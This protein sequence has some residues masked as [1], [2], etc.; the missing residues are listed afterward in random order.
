MLPLEGDLYKQSSSFF[1]FFLKKVEIQA[2]STHS[3]APVFPLAQPLEPPCTRERSE[4]VLQV[5]WAVE[6][7]ARGI[8][9]VLTVKAHDVSL[10][11]QYQAGF[12]RETASQGFNSSGV[13][14]I[15]SAEIHGPCRMYFSVWFVAEKEQFSSIP[16]EQSGE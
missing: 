5:W 8:L 9:A 12:P 7:N 1:F 13:A 2:E 15:P 4:Q 10:V 3:S 14:Y 16:W 6:L 11:Q